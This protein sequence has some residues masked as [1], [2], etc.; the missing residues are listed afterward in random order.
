VVIGFRT[1]FLALRASSG[2]L[3]LSP[4]QPP[5]S[6][7]APAVLL[8]F[9][10]PFSFLPLFFWEKKSGEEINALRD[11]RKFYFYFLKVLDLRQNFRPFFRH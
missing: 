1:T 8:R 7:K 2:S 6:R 4:L 5:S 10:G 11:V 9:P 3:A